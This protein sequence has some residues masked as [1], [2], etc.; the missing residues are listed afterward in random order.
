MHRFTTYLHSG[1]VLLTAPSQLGIGLY[2]QVSKE[3]T[4]SPQ[5]KLVVIKAGRM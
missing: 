3:M 1:V 4:P 2:D 5:N